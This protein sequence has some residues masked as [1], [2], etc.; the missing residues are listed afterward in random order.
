V[1]HF[2]FSAKILENSAPGTN[3]IRL[4]VLNQNI[5]KAIKGT[6]VSKFGE[7]RYFAIQPSTPRLTGFLG[8]D[9]DVITGSQPLDRELKKKYVFTCIV[10][11]ADQRTKR[12][13]GLSILS[14]RK[15]QCKFTNLY[16]VSFLPMLTCRLFVYFV[17][18]FC[19]FYTNIIFKKHQNTQKKYS[20]FTKIHKNFE[21]IPILYKV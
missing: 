21:K 1:L 18:N 20:F 10:A 8:K 2:T 15:R 3:V 7:Q 5:N 16:W 9:L 11:Y 17:Q 12:E 19:S 6:M 14:R 4:D 13:V